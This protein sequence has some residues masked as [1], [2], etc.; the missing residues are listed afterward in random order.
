MEKLVV[1]K[2]TSLLAKTSATICLAYSGSS[3]IRMLSKTEP[4]FT[5]CQYN[6]SFTN[7]Y[8][9]NNNHIFAEQNKE[10]KT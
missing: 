1:K 4:A 5:C 9:P 7:H 2:L 8:F 10:C 6:I 3:Q